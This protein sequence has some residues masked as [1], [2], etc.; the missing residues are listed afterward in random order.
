M[1]ADR[2]ETSGVHSTEGTTL[3]PH[4]RGSARHAEYP[5]AY[6]WE[7]THCEPLRTT[8]SRA[9]TIN[10]RELIRAFARSEGVLWRA[11]QLKTMTS[12]PRQ[13]SPPSTK[14]SKTGVAW[15]VPRRP[16]PGRRGHIRVYRRRSSRT[17]RLEILG[18]G[19]GRYD[20]R[21]NV[22]GARSRRRRRPTRP[23]SASPCGAR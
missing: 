7:S 13:S 12:R 1:E 10:K 11:V 23:R 17:S 3:T 8:R 5:T 14:S 21:P 16:V 4:R 20:D 22:V 6:C 2:R 9:R 18:G 19:E 15:T